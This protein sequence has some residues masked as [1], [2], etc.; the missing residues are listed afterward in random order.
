LLSAIPVAKL[1]HGKRKNCIIRGEVS[2]PINPKPG[3]R[4]AP[5]CA[6]CS[7]KCLEQDFK[8]KEISSGH[9]V[10]CHLYE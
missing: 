1:S 5:R 6:S 8:L 7:N 3:C 9:F 2:D 4:F 10:A